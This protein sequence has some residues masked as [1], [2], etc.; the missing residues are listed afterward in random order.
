MARSLWWEAMVTTNRTSQVLSIKLVGDA[1]ELESQIEAIRQRA[2]GRGGGRGSRT[3]TGPGRQPAQPGQRTQR[4]EPRTRGQQAQETLTRG[5]GDV[6]IQRLGGPLGQLGS[7]ATRA[8]AALGP[9]GIAAGGVAGGLVAL[10]AAGIKASF[11][12]NTVASREFQRNFNELK[13]AFTDLLSVVGDLI[14]PVLSQFAIALTNIID[15]I[16]QILGRRQR[17]REGVGAETFDVPHS[18]S[19]GQVAGPSEAPRLHEG[20]RVRGSSEGTTVVIGDRNRDEAVVPLERTTNPSSP[21]NQ[22]QRQQNLRDFWHWLYSSGDL[23]SLLNELNT[24]KLISQP[25]QIT[26]STAP[27]TVDIG[28]TVSYLT[29]TAYDALA[30]KD[31]ATIYAIVN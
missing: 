12:L 19:P 23:Q 4:R 31:A 14:L 18:S 29:Q 27:L 13:V 30:T 2:Q 11:A 20:G 6:G 15:F 21:E 7:V 22:R 25:V 26:G 9:V 16:N 10:A 3:T 1:S 5:I 24:P 17:R 28:R 8:A